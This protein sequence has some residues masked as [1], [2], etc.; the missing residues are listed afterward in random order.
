MEKAKSI[1]FRLMCPHDGTRGEYTLATEYQLLLGDELHEKQA[2]SASQDALSRRLIQS[3]Y[4]IFTSC[5]NIAGPTARAENPWLQIQ[6][7][8]GI[9]DNQ[10][11][12]DF[13][14]H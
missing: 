12:S 4:V 10:T 13:G 7:S 14:R 1:S 3:M 2:A 8:D 9:Y 11:C 5:G 6:G